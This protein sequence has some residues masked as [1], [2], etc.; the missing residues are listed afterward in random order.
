[1]TIVKDILVAGAALCAGPDPASVTDLHRIEP[2]WS[3]TLV[4]CTG[5]CGLVIGSLGII[6]T[7]FRTSVWWG[8]GCLLVSL[9]Q[10]VFVALYWRQAR[11]WF[12]I[13][14]AGLALMF[15]T[16]FLEDVCGLH[17]HFA[18]FPR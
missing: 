13:Q 4:L 9:L 7:A 18:D 14:I 10:W 17:T 3:A 1:M 2:S 6:F 11:R 8:I 16:G 5:V 12:A 15:L